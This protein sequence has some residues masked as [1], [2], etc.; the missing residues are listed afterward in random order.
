M[1]SVFNKIMNIRIF[2]I[3]CL[4]ILMC[5]VLISA[6]NSWIRKSSVTGDLPVPNQGNQQTCCVVCDIDKDGIDD[7]IIGERTKTPSV[8]WYKWSGDGWNRYIIDNT[9]LN[10]EAG[11]E[12]CDVDKDGD[13][14]IILGQDA[15]GNQIWWWENPYPDFNK[16]WIRRHI[17]NSGKSKH[18][19][20]SVADY[21]GDGDVELV[22]WNQRAKQLLFYEI[23][24][25]PKS[26]EPWEPTVI[27]SWDSGRELEGFPSQPVDVDL[28]GK[29]DIVGGGRWFKHKGG[30]DFEAHVIDNEMRFT[31]CAAGQLIE[32]GRPEIVFSPGDMNGYIKWYQWKD[33]KWVSQVLRYIIHGHTCE[34]RD[35]NNDGHMD[36]FI[37]EMGQPGNADN[38]RLFIWY[39]DGEGNFHETIVYRGQ[40][41]HEGLLSDLDGDGDLDILV[42]PYHHKSPRI[43]VLLNNSKKLS[44]NKW[45]RHHIADLPKRAMFIEAGDLDNDGYRDLVCGGWW[46]KNP[47]EAGGNWQQKVIGEPF[48]NLATLYDFDRDGD[49][50]AVGT[51]G[52][53]S[54]ANHQFVWA[55]NDGNGNF[56]VLSN[57]DTGGDGDFLQGRIASNFAN[58]VMVLLSWHNGGGGVQALVVPDEPSKN[59]WE[60]KTISQTTEKEDLDLG[61]IDRD[62]DMDVLLGTHWLRNDD[63]QWTPYKLGSI[64]EGE[65]DRIDLADIN[66]NGRLD[67]M[68]GLELSTDIYW[69]ESP[70]DPTQSWTRHKINNIAGQ[71]FSMDTA[72][73]DNDGDPDVVFGEHRG[74]EKNRGILF[75]NQNGTSWKEHII[76]S[77]SKNEIDHHDGTQAIDIDFD[78]DLDIISIGWYNPKVWL[79]E[80]KAIDK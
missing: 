34:I 51:K 25:D 30:D 10:P 5:P 27:Y 35:V 7:F 45:E 73:F 50:D 67:V 38:A 74:P 1:K 48:R 20:Q 63:G 41:I 8:V 62:G 37:G 33:G 69:F 13:V 57:I 68:M 4:L 55:R 3:T 26:T 53:G 39:G 2:T 22:S 78:G 36:I 40:G 76:D 32:G 60:F 54:E 17:K 52:V 44:L 29:V 42:K 9:L 47:G 6:N 59:Q 66:Q 58:K 61:D 21:D 19:D 46:W 15:S 79:F 16:P 43:D 72:D 31:Q 23:P 14:D 64:P 77:G 49:L 65:S 70:L 56:D 24:A 12:T 11:G 71:G 80:N 18:H 28:D 75:E